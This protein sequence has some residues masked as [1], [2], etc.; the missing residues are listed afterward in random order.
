[1]NQSNLKTFLCK[2]GFETFTIKARNLKD[3]IEQCEIWNAVVLYEIK[4]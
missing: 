3:A 2:E 4:D 1:M